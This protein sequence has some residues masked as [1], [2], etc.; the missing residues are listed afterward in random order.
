MLPLDNA[1]ADFI[2]S[3][4]GVLRLPDLTS[5]KS[6]VN[7]CARVLRPGGV[8]MLWF[9][10]LTRLPFAP[11]GKAWLRGFDLRPDLVS[12][13]NRLH[14]RMFHARRA[15]RSA[16]MNTPSLST[17]LHPDTSW[18][19]FRGGDLSYITAHKPR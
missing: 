6:L 7:E 14:I 3:L 13:A 11:P 9:G 10:R 17:P 16:G 4:H 8:A 12:G 5:F 15:A 1:S 18:R 2:Y 19:L